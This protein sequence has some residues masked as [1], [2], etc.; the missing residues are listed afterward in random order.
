MR[1]RYT[2]QNAHQAIARSRAGFGRCGMPGVCWQRTRVSRR[3]QGKQMRK[4]GERG[5][6]PFPALPSLKTEALAGC[7]YFTK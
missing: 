4:E 5:I 3:F 7:K 2:G 6:L 1:I